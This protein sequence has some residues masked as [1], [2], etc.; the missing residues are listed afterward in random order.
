MAAAEANLH[1][2]A[3]YDAK[4]PAALARLLKSGAKLHAFPQD[5][6]QA[7]LRIANEIFN[8][9]AAKNPAFKKIYEPWVRFR[10]D[11]FQWA[12]IAE[13]SYAN[14]TFNNVK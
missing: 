9:E 8:E 3:E 1:M 5:M 4:N 14:F 6:M 12:R 10:N 11:Q 13:S 2:L 7:A